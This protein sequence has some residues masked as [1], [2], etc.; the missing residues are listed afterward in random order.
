MSI[1][2]KQIDTFYIHWACTPPATSIT[3]NIDFVNRWHTSL[4]VSFEA[5]QNVRPPVY[6][7]PLCKLNWPLKAIE[8]QNPAIS[9]GHSITAPLVVFP[10]RG[11]S[12]LLFVLKLQKRKFTD[13]R[14]SF[15]INT[16]V[17]FEREERSEG[18]R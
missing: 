5:I 8:G 16:L 10:L 14:I 6:V 9:F 18:G 15:Q 4:S 17:T 13:R 11:F 12:T 3:F 2:G 1:S 7:S